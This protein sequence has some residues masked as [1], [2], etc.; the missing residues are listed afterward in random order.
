M[1]KKKYLNYLKL[2]GFHFYNDTLKLNYSYNINDINKCKICDLYKIKDNFYINSTKKASIFILS[3]NNLKLN[4]KNEFETILKSTLNLE[5]KNIYFTSIVKCS[6]NFDTKHLNKCYY[7]ALNE[8]IMSEAKIL[9]LLGFN[10]KNILKLDNINIGEQIF[11]K[12]NK[13]TIKILLNYDFYFIK[14]NPSYKNDFINNFKKIKENY[15]KNFTNIA[16]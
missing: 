3:W 16:N 9:I 12:F 1:C 2:F 13:K 15:E 4:D 11:Y 10:L 14:Q 6:N 7:Y 8:F 5:L